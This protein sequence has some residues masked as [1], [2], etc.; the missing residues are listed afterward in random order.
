MTQAQLAEIAGVAQSTAGTWLRGEFSPG[1]NE[2]AKLCRHFKVSA[3]YLLGISDFQSGLS[4]DSWIVDLDEVDNPR[5]DRMW[6][7]KVPRRARIVDYE[8]MRRIEVE[9]E[10]KRRGRRK[11]GKAQGRGDGKA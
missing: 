1:V 4:P 5:D 6:C 3:D 10:A 2:L 7:V 11:G 8:E 9:T